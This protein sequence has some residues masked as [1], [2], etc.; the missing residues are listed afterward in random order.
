MSEA[1]AGNA[2]DGFPPLDEI[3]EQRISRRP[4]RFEPDEGRTDLIRDAMACPACGTPPENLEWF[5]FESPEW[6][7]QALCGRAGWVSL[8]PTEG[9]PVE[10]FCSI[11]S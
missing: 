10:F 1:R 6:T 7:C 8:C 5:W 11:L 9:R 2:W 4:R 3:L